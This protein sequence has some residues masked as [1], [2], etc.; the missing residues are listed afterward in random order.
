M[1]GERKIE[2]GKLI[3]FPNPNR[4]RDYEITVEFP[5]F[6]CK[7]PFSGYPDFANLRLIYQPNKKVIELKAIKLYLNN[8]RDKKISHEEVANQIIDDLV[9]ASDPKW[10]QIEA[11]F[12]PR[13]NVH[14]IIRVCHGKRNNLELIIQ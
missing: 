14:T 3:C 6:T 4:N 7:C 1:Y 12:N 8:F 2:N 9:E 10:I 11:D 13:G 5:E